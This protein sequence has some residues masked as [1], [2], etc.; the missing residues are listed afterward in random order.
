MKIRY[1]FVVHKS[2][3]GKRLARK[4]NKR[5]K[6]M[7]VY[8]PEVTG[9]GPVHQWLDPRRIKHLVKF[10]EE[11]RNQHRFTFQLDPK[12]KKQLAEFMTNFS[13]VHVGF[14]FAPST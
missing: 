4:E 1:S 9:E 12:D 8:V 5:L 13:E 3:L 7:N 14:C 2:A 6:G 11:Q 10:Y